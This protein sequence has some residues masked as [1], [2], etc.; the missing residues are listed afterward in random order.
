MHKQHPLP[1]SEPLVHL[2]E[3]FGE[4]VL[5]GAEVVLPGTVRA[6]G[7]PRLQVPLVV[8]VLEV[9]PSRRTGLA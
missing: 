5:A 7:E 4:P 3:A 1:V 6:V 8:V 2:G 9:L